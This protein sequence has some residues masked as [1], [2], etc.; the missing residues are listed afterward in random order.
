VSVGGGV[1]VDR[2][3]GGGGASQ[4]EAE[5]QGA[6]QIAHDAFRRGEAHKDG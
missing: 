4:V 1:H 5:A 6:L 2:Q 3:L